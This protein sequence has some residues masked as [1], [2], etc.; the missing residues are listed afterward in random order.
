M[1]QLLTAHLAGLVA[2][3]ENSEGCQREQEENDIKA[4]ILNVMHIFGFHSSWNDARL[5]YLQQCYTKQDKEYGRD[6]YSE[7]EQTLVRDRLLFLFH[8]HRRYITGKG[9]LALIHLAWKPY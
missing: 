7:L 5:Y 4:L 9:L 3:A 1:A 2:R 8:M 6:I